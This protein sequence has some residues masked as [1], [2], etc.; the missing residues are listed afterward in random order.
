M[1]L[2]ENIDT[3]LAFTYNLSTKQK[4]AEY[5]FGNS[6]YI[7]TEIMGSCSV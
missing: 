3:I 2:S 4:K 7:V 1:E 5:F 6:V